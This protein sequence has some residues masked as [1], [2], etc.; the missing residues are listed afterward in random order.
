MDR[1][2]KP[3]LGEVDLGRFDAARGPLEAK[4]GLPSQVQFCRKCVIS[5]QRPNSAREYENTAGSDKQTIRFDD[6][7]PSVNVTKGSDTGGV[8]APQDAQTDGD[9]TDSDTAP[10]TIEKNVLR[11]NRL[12]FMPSA[13]I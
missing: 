4:Y 11:I 1:Y 7:G 2:P 8:L 10:T 13:W 3:T 9:P 5:N 12:T 6:D